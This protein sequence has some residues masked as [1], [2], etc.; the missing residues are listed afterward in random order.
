MMSTI[1]ICQLLID[2]EIATQ[3]SLHFVIHFVQI[4]YNYYIFLVQT[5]IFLK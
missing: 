3:L 4:R 1:A 2:S 5:N